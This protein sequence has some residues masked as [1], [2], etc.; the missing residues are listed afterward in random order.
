[1][2]HAVSDNLTLIVGTKVYLKKVNKKESCALTST[3]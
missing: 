1:M 3:E 2:G